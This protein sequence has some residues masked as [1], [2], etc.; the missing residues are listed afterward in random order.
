MYQLF[1]FSCQYCVSAAGPVKCA[2]IM[3]SV[4]KLKRVLYIS[5]ISMF[6]LLICNA[7]SSYDLSFSWDAI[8][9]HP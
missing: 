9:D 7:V 8:L 4:L 6:F 2:A 3:L 5:D 1:S